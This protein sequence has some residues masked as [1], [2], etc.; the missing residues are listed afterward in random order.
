MSSRDGRGDVHR[1]SGRGGVGGGNDRSGGRKDEPVLYGAPGR[2][3]VTLT[4]GTGGEVDPSD[5]TLVPSRI[6]E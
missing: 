5:L 1:T 4:E 3:V 6:G 2:P